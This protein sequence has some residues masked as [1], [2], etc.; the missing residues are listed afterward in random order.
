LLADA[1]ILR[2]LPNSWLTGRLRIPFGHYRGVAIEIDRLRRSKRPVHGPDR[3]AL[4]AAAA[5]IGRAAEVISA[6]RVNAHEWR[7]LRSPILAAEPEVI[8]ACALVEMTAREVLGTSALE[9]M[10]VETSG[11]AWALMGV[12]QNVLEA[13]A[14]QMLA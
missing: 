13:D 4:P 9:A 8:A 2:S 3:N 10:R 6:A 7:T 14:P 11:L 1:P 5:F 12:A